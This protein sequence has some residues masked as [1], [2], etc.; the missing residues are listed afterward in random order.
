MLCSLFQGPDQFFSGFCLVHAAGRTCV[1]RLHKYRILEVSLYCRNRDIHILFHLPAHHRNIFC[2]AD[3]QGIYDDLCIQLIHGYR[4]SQHTTA[5]IRDLCQLEQAL[6][7][8]VLAVKAV[9]HRKCHIDP[10]F[11]GH[12]VLRNESALLCC[13]RGDNNLHAAL[14]PG[15]GTDILH[16]LCL[17]P[18]SLLGNADEE[19]VILFFIY[20]VNHI[21][22]RHAGY[23]ML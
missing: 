8:T 21:G 11:S 14:S 18:V 7:S 2:L 5:Y 17:H 15:S 22:R 6:N 3:A 12:A 16:A 19:Q 13:V 9:E 1:G 23:Y 4:G 10:L 20:L